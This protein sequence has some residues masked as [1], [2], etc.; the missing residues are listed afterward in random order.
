MQLLEVGFCSR[1]LDSVAC[2]RTS[3]RESEQWFWWSGGEVA[4][5]GDGGSGHSGPQV[6]AGW[7]RV[8]VQVSG[9]TLLSI[10]ER[11]HAAILTSESVPQPSSRQRSA[12]QF[13]ERTFGELVSRW[14]EGEGHRGPQWDVMASDGP[15]HPHVRR[16]PYQ[17]DERTFIELVG[18]PAKPGFP[19][20]GF[21]PPIPA[22][23]LRVSASRA[24]S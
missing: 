7:P 9:S 20:V 18:C 23:G 10:N 5:I 13:V 2:S 22:C 4:C 11:H 12:Y 6:W 8:S 24:K 16:A 21:C 15:V 17:L 19:S 1:N 3:L 14:T